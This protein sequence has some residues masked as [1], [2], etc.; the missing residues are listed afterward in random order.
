M[1]II[2]TPGYLLC[3]IVLF[4]LTLCLNGLITSVTVDE[5]FSTYGP[6]MI[7]WFR[8]VFLCVMVR[9]ENVL[10]CCIQ[11]LTDNEREIAMLRRG[12]SFIDRMFPKWA[13]CNFYR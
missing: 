12:Y 13:K 7:H 6:D 5:G 9:H 3:E 4:V 2:F 10:K 11:R 8:F 1:L